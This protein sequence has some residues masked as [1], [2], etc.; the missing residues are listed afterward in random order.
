MVGD[1]FMVIPSITVASYHRGWQ[2]L[3]IVHQWCFIVGIC[4][5][6]FHYPNFTDAGVPVYMY[7]FQ[8]RPSIFKDLKPSFVKADHGDDLG[9]VFGACF[10]D[11][12]IKVGMQIYELVCPGKL[13]WYWTFILD[14]MTKVWNDWNKNVN[15]VNDEVVMWLWISTLYHLQGLS[16]RRKTNYAEPSW[17]TGQTLF[18]LGKWYISY[19]TE[20]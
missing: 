6:I 13:L 15:D 4:L 14:N 12:H 3:A 20:H 9:F 10:W 11:G 18:A 16:L 1:L 7:E 5:I 17:D 8:Q 19:W 2:T